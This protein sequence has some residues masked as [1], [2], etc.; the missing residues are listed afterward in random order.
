MC[1][2]LINEILWIFFF[3]VFTR[4]KCFGNSLSYVFLSVWTRTLQD[5]R[6]GGGL[7]QVGAVMHVLQFFS[8][9]ECTFDKTHTRSH[10][11][12]SPGARRRIPAGHMSCS[13]FPVPCSLFPLSP[14]P[15][16]IS[17]LHAFLSAA[18]RSGP[19]FRHENIWKLCTNMSCL[20]RTC[21]CVCV[22]ACRCQCMGVSMVA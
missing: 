16:T 20:S 4:V 10:L 8:R 3:R 17:T 5:G 21:V 19:N 11:S 12:V 22:C 18:A 1:R 14:V 9:N 6:V 2:I 15:R 7:W 13:Q